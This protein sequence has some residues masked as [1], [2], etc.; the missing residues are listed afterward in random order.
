MRHQLYGEILC[1]ILI[2][3]HKV[4]FTQSPCKQSLPSLLPSHF[5]GI[6]LEKTKFIKRFL[7]FAF[8]K[9]TNNQKN[10]ITLSK[11]LKILKKIKKLQCSKYCFLNH[12][13]SQTSFL[14]NAPFLDICSVFRPDTIFKLLLMPSQDFLFLLFLSKLRS[15]LWLM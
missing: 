4:F 9:I 8:T 7:V 2:K 15:K 13:Y 3:V 1:E 5:T 10:C 6:K 14:N 12:K 11:E